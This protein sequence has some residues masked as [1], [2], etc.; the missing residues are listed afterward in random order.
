[1]RKIGIFQAVLLVVFLFAVHLT[2]AEPP[3]ASDPA[4]AKEKPLSPMMQEIKAAME[5]NTAVVEALQ[6][7][8]E[9]TFD[10]ELS[11]QILRTISQQQMDSEI[12]IL[13]IQ[14]R[15]ALEAGDNETAGKIHQAVERILNPD[16]VTPTAEAMA[17]R[18]TR[19]AGGS[20]HE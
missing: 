1:M 14:E 4:P 19:R 9:S 18:Q 12:R 10:E 11:L 2:A 7:Q 20:D 6:E 5:S 8:L 15:F 13:R 17:E 3:I 16:P